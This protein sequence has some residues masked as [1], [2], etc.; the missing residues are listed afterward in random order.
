MVGERQVPGLGLY[1]GW[2]TGSDGWGSQH[3]D[4]IIEESVRLGFSVLSRTTSLPGSPTNGDI[5]IVPSGDTNGNQIAARDNG[6][7]V[8]FPATRQPLW[9]TDETGYVHWD[10]TAWQSGLPTPPLR[11]L[12][13]STGRNLTAADFDGRTL[14]EMSNAAAQSI[15]IPSGLTVSRPVTVLQGGSGTVT[16]AA[17]GG[18][19]LRSAGSLFDLAGLNAVA[20]IA[21]TD[22]ANEY[23]LFGN[24][25]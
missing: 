20:T 25:A 8:Y 18:V 4:G 17:G 3:D 16:I 14:L 9:V 23:L 15:T 2:T 12:A 13:E 10:G 24:L 21:P 19:T 5:Y 22:T 6:A 1:A 7:W 11:F